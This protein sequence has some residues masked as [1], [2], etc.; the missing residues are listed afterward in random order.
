[1]SGS[2]I[3]T[4]TLDLLV[5]R[6][7]SGGA[8]HGYAVGR[9]IRDGSAGVLDVEEGVL[10]PALHRLEERGLL[11]SRWRP[12]ESGRRAKFY[13][14]TRKGEKSLTAAVR[15]WDA[16]TGAVGAILRDGAGS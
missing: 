10:Y 15:E 4:G 12:S 16:V 1:V 6:I 11:R 9:A 14:L 13:E 5:L 3:I 2:N 7:L 8:L